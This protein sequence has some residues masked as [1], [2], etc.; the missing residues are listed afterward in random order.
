MILILIPQKLFMKSSFFLMI[1]VSNT[2]KYCQIGL[3]II[4][5][6]LYWN[7]NFTFTSNPFIVYIPDVFDGLS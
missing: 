2:Y 3:L 1:Q 5:K 7:E 4:Y 6:L